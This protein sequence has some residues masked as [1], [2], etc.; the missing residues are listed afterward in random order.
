MSSA[1]DPKV[2]IGLPVYNGAE[3]I[4]LALEALQAQTFTPVTEGEIVSN[5]IVK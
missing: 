3:Y 4:A 1:T 5:M 2:G